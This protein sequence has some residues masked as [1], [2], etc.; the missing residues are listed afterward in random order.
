[1]KIYLDPFE[2]KS[3]GTM[4]KFNDTILLCCSYFMFLFTDFVPSLDLRN[5]LGWGYISFIGF[6]VSAN[7]TLLLRSGSLTFVK[8]CKQQ[9]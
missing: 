9:Y 1:M 7:I 6:M 3:T 5:N 8:W 4:E 2:S